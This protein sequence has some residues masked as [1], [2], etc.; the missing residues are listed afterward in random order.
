MV[1]TGIASQAKMIM[2]DDGVFRVGESTVFKLHDLADRP[3]VG[4]SGPTATLVHG[5]LWILGLLPP[6]SDGLSIE[7]STGVVTVNVGSIDIE[8]DGTEST[9]TVYDRGATVEHGKQTVF[10]VTGEQVIAR[11]ASSL[12]ISTIPTVSFTDDRVVKNLDQDAV[13]RH[14]ISILQENRRQKLVGIL[15]TSFL[16]PAKRLAE[17]VDVFFTLT[18]DGRT[19]KRIARANTRLNEAVALMKAGQP[20]EAAAPLSEYRD[21]LIAMAG[22]TQDNLVKH[23]L[24]RQIADASVTLGSTDSASANIDLLKSA[25]AEVGTAVPDAHL[26]A[27]D[28]EG[29]VL[30]D[31]LAQINQQLANSRDL[32]G[33]VSAYAAIRPY[34]KSLLADGSGVHPLLQKEA[35]SLLVTTSTLLQEVQKTNQDSVLIALAT[36]IA[37]YLP[38]EAE[39]VRISEAEL[40]ARVQSMYARIFIFRAPLS[41]Y[42]QLQV[43]MA[44][45]KGDPNHGTLLRRLKAA[46]PVTLGEYVNTE[47]K[48]LGDE[49]KTESKALATQGSKESVELKEL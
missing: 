39:D 33:A 20:H 47:I 6:V 3:T 37:P 31:R 35:T 18:Q 43:E 15:P 30:V 10:A 27:K 14:E 25:L 48:L 7:I 12:H 32:Q 26:D 41:R 22:D 13:H 23:L 40:N 46:L 1:R 2:N 24:R 49:L 21:S 34:I 9:V 38:S 44:G 36:D 45:L 5:K 4:T 28:I 17:H 42:N 29:Y 16:Y 11:G 8:D 19:E